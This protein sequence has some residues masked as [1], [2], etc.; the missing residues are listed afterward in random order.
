VVGGCVLSYGAAE[1]NAQK[2]EDYY[3]EKDTSPE[4]S[5]LVAMAS[6]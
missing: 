6:W 1:A 4:K 3:F 2:E 5:G